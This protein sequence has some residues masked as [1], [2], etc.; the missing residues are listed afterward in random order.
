MGYSYLEKKSYFKLR[1]N[2]RQQKFVDNYVL[3]GGNGT[4][5]VMSA[6]YKANGKGSASSIAGKLLQHSGIKKA[7]TIHRK[8][9][10]SEMK[11]T[12]DWK[13]NKLT[14]IVD[15]FV[16]DNFAEVGLDAKE[17]NTAIS[18]IVELNRM[19]GHHSAEKHINQNTTIDQDVEKV[20]ELMDMYRKE[21]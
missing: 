3:N 14:A 15:S 19:Q 18:S 2:E 9:M 5:A 21:S 17:A 1:L 12:F 10:D 6:G 13:V 4:D 20:G 7:I 16:P 11:A 8:R